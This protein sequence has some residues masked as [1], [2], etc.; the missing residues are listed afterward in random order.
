MELTQE[1][2]TALYKNTIQYLHDVTEKVP[3]T[4]SVLKSYY[5]SKFTISQLQTKINLEGGHSKYDPRCRKCCLKLRQSGASYAVAPETKKSKFAQKLLK[6]AKRKQPLTKFQAKYLKKND[7]TPGNRLIVTCTFCQK[8]ATYVLNKPVKVRV[9][10][11]ANQ[12][13][14][15]RAKKKKNKKKDKFCGLQKEAV[16]SAKRANVNSKQNEND[17]QECVN[18]VLNNPILKQRENQKKKKNLKK[19]NSMLKQSSQLKAPKNNLAQ[20]LQSLA[21]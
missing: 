16:V 4:L 18:R 17:N 14:Q 13:I 3:N 11:N 5:A 2:A 20:F 12:P 8:K 10:V 21:K 19:L 15:G 1:I 7:L 9:D 6:K